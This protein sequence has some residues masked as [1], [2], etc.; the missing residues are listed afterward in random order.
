MNRLVLIGNG[1]DL[2]HKIPTSYN[3]FVLWY[4]KD[5]FTIAY[6]D[7]SYEDAL[8]KIQRNPNGWGFPIANKQN[9]SELIDHFY[10][11][12]IGALFD[13]FLKFPTHLND[14]QNPFLF[15]K[16][17]DF[18]TKL[19]ANCSVTSWVD[20]ENEFYTQLKYILKVRD[21]DQLADLNNGMECIILKLQHYLQSI[22]SPSLDFKYRDIFTDDFNFKEFNL[23]IRKRDGPLLVLPPESPGT[24]KIINFNYTRTCEPYIKD[25]KPGIEINYIHGE[26]FNEDNPIIFGF[27]DELDKD[28]EKLADERIKGFLRYIKSFWYLKTNNYHDLSRFIDSDFFQVCILGHSCG[29]SDRTMLNMIF[30]H[31]NCKSIKIYYYVDADNKNNFTE[32]T[33]E[34]S[35][36]FKDKGMFRKKVVNFKYSS[37]MPQLLK[38]EVV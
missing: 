9:V 21:R 26:L 19:L 24:V 30:E 14:F 12:N 13:S 18:L 33:E 6:K 11:C 35:R 16:K 28:Y 1:F 27:G 2:A 15:P 7:H 17:S 23:G 20:I 29:L 8:I 37:P 34:I 31:E 32:L 4:L 36:H 10:N 5:C 38:K 25:R 22:D 3:D